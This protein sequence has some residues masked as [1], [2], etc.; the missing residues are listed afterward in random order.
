MKVWNVDVQVCGPGSGLTCGWKM[1][2]RF[3]SGQQWWRHGRS[4]W[5]VCGSGY[6][7]QLIKNLRTNKDLLQPTNYNL[8]EPHSGSLILTIVY[9]TDFVYK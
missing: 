8:S 7:S 6:S 1:R 3:S 4:V 5:M 2:R 9:E